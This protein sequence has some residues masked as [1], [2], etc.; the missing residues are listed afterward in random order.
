[1]RRRLIRKG[2]WISV[3]PV[4]GDPEVLRGV[5]A[6]AALA[7]G[8]AIEA[9]EAD[10][11]SI[12]MKSSPTDP[13]TSADTSAESAVRDLLHQRRPHDGYVGEESPEITTGSSEVRWVVDALDGSVNYLYGIPH[14]CVSVACQQSDGSRWQTVAAAVFDVVRNE[15]FTASIGAG[16]KRDELKIMVNDPVAPDFA[17]VAVEFSYKA[18]S[19]RRQGKKV[20]KMVPK[21]RDVRS[22]GSSALDLCWVACGRLDGFAEDELSQWDH[23]AGA[24]IVREAGGVVS[25]W[26]TGV[27]AAGPRLHSALVDLAGASSQSTAESGF[28]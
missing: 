8:L 2:G 17:L 26:G 22:F 6:Q 23:A 25:P 24:L 10:G 28:D 14:Y 27:I 4:A 3:I 21:L 9:Q 1:M 12:T 16:A 11:A 18:K 19:R 20:A 15:L 13:V 7:G 5:A